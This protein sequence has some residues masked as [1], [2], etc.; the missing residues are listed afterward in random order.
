MRMPGAVVSA[1][2]GGSSKHSNEIVC[3]LVVTMKL[4]VIKL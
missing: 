1:D 4:R 2:L 3:T